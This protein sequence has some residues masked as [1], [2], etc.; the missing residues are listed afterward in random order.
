[1]IWPPGQEDGAAGRPHLSTSE[2]AT[3]GKMQLRRL[4]K[5]GRD[6]TQY[7]FCPERLFG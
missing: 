4:S 1:L 7:C 5:R 3:G 6:L 2:R